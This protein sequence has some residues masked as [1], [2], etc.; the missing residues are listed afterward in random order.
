[1][2]AFLFN[3]LRNGTSNSL[4]L[5]TYTWPINFLF[6]NLFNESVHLPKGTVTGD[7]LD[8]R[9]S[10]IRCVK[11]RFEIGLNFS[12]MELLNFPSTL[13][14]FCHF[15]QEKTVAEIKKMTCPTRRADLIM[16]CISCIFD[17]RICYYEGSSTTSLTYIIPLTDSFFVLVKFYCFDGADNIKDIEMAFNTSIFRMQ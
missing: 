12:A 15:D 14:I 2:A 4:Y 11:F 6:I 10:I 7:E 5:Y 13:R 8:W 3:N 9:V 16:A 1:M 17:V